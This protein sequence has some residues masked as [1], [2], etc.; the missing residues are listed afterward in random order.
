[1]LPSCFR[2]LS[3][4]RVTELH[5]GSLLV[6]SNLWNWTQDL[7]T[8]LRVIWGT[9]SVWFFDFAFVAWHWNVFFKMCLCNWILLWQ[10]SVLSQESPW[11][12]DKQ[13]NPCS[14]SFSLVVL[15]VLELR[16]VL[17]ASGWVCVVS[18]FSPLQSFHR[19]SVF[20]HNLWCSIDFT[21]PH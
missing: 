20:L 4:V 6:M 1:M 17:G 2:V 21:R 14:I 19:C 8:R 18:H 15:A 13:M 9:G 12:C 3:S 11:W 5:D 16:H 7:R 10:Q